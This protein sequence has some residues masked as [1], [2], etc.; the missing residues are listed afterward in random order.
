MQQILTTHLPFNF[1]STVRSHGWYQ[2]AP[3]QWDEATKVL[4]KPEALSRGKVVLLEISEHRDGLTVSVDE[5]LSAEE[6]AELTQKLRWMFWLDSDFSEFYAAADQEPRLVHCR[7]KSYGRL[8]RS[9]TLFEDV[10]RVMMTTNI[11]WS[12]TKRLVAKLVENFGA[13]LP[14]SIILRAFPTP[15]AVANSDEVTLRSLG[16]GY[17]SPYL[18]KLA[19]GIVSGQIQLESFRDEEKPTEQLRKEILKLPGI[20]PYAAATVLSILGRFDYIGVDSEAVSS[21]SKYFYEGKPV[22]EK[23]VYAIFGKWGK[24]KALAYWFWDFSGM[25]LSPIEQYENKTEGQR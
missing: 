23:E 10:V 21:V 24:Y 11:Q 6:E 2:L 5:P 1:E 8:L 16:L 17:R 25:Q 14:Q 12:G 18:L 19:Q 13:P 15:Q 20:G 4:R 7:I 3:I 9:T 22:G